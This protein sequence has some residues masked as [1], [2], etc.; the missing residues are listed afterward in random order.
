MQVGPAMRALLGQDSVMVVRRPF[1][2]WTG[3]IPSALLL[4]ELLWAHGSPT[5]EW[6]DGALV[7]SDR[8]VMSKLMLTRRQIETARETLVGMGLIK[9]ARSCM[10]ARMCY[11]IDPDAVL[12][13]F[14]EWAAE[15]SDLL[16]PHAGDA[17]DVAVAT[18]L[19]LAGPGS[20]QVDHRAE[21]ER[22]YRQ[23]FANATHGQARAFGS[24]VDVALEMGW[25][26]EDVWARWDATV[27]A[28]VESGDWERGFFNP[29]TAHERFQGAIMSESN[30]QST[31]R[32]GS[33]RV[34]A[35]Y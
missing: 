13:A 14:A 7:A 8:K 35:E 31:R 32:P 16:A 19:G 11:E 29:R 18:I 24:V 27:A 26:I 6:V 22:R 34:V 33:T 23:T 2:R 4:D 3:S 20:T 17:A 25:S 9:S 10:P 5:T 12:A 30:R 15:Q 1:V 21:A 28:A